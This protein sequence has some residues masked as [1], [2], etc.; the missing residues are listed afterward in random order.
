MENSTLRIGVDRLHKNFSPK[1][2]GAESL[3][4]LWEQVKNEPDTCVK[5]AVDKL[6]M[7]FSQLPPLSKLVQYI[8]EN[9]SIGRENEASKINA[10]APN[11]FQV[12]PATPY[13]RDCITLLKKLFDGQI[14][15][16]EYLKGCFN[17]MDKHNKPDDELAT[18]IETEWQRVSERG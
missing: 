9:A 6:V 10:N 3:T 17:V 12:E 5:P 15:Y 11:L 14:S 7:E 4:V 16:P 8:R 2:Y 1:K 18:F 13:G